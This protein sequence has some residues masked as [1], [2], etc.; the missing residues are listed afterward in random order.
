MPQTHR[1]YEHSDI[2][3]TKRSSLKPVAKGTEQKKGLV[4]KFEDNW[5]TTSFTDVKNGLVSDLAQ[6]AL[7]LLGTVLINTISDIFGTGRPRRNQWSTRPATRDNYVRYNDIQ[8][9]Q[10]RSAYSEGRPRAR[11]DMRWITFDTKD[12]ASHVLDELIDILETEGSVSLLQYYVASS[13]P[14]SPKDD[15]FGWTN[16]NAARVKYNIDEDRWEIIFPRLEIL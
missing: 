13:Q 10:R 1:Q 3:E 11:G 15:E 16:L 2:D 6:G 9:K 4:K 12:D 7:S 5:M 8:P 14:H